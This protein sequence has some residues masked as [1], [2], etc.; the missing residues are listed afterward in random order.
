MPADCGC[1]P[2]SKSRRMNERRFRIHGFEE[3]AAGGFNQ[4]IRF[5]QGAL[6]ILSGRQLIEILENDNQRRKTGWFLFTCSVLVRY[7]HHNIKRVYGY[8]HAGTVTECISCKSV[9]LIT[10][11]TNMVDF[12]ET[13]LERESTFTKTNNLFEERKWMITTCPA[14]LQYGIGC[15]SLTD[16]GIT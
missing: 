1:Q 7:H 11:I 9:K 5:P 4:P 16:P 8:S 13:D 12:L 3:K 15:Q 14:E 10:S 6:H 2:F